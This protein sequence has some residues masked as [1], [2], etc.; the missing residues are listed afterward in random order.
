MYSYQLYSSA[1][2]SPAQLKR[3]FPGWH[4]GLYSLHTPEVLPAKKSKTTI[5]EHIL[6]NSF[7]K[8]WNT[9]RIFIDFLFSLLANIAFS[10]QY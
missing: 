7:S 2:I 8:H 3:N 1:L 6:D 4:I 9:D 5:M 10:Y